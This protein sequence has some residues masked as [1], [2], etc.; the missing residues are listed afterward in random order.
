MHTPTWRSLLLPVLLATTAAA[1][2]AQTEIN[3]TV[4][5]AGSLPGDAAGY[6]VTINEPGHYRLSGNL[7][8][9]LNVN[10]IV[11]KAPGVTLDLNGY[12]VSS[13]VVC[14]HDT[15]TYRV[16]CNVANVHG[17]VVG[18]SGIVVEWEAH[19][20]VV[21]NGTVS[22]FR[23]H[24][25]VIRGPGSRVERVRSQSNRYAGMSLQMLYSNVHVSESTSQ[26]NGDHGFHAYHAF[27]ERVT[28][29]R[30]GGSG[31]YNSAGIVV[32]SHVTMNYRYGVEG[33]VDAGKVGVRDSM[34]A[35]NKMLN[36]G[37]SAVSMGG[38]KTQSWLF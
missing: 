3:H 37:P 1:A 8:V 20:S 33:W 30:N 19:G 18:K 34:V 10:A 32:D 27:L 9:P 5:M 13:S 29:S 25:L 38:N 12:T 26:F 4:A 24:G 28:S 36:M 23:G 6:P 11:V 14:N 2:H 7:E 21:R 31:V 35:W 22:G 15:Q 17:D 16:T